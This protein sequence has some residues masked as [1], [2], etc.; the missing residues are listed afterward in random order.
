MPPGLRGRPPGTGAADDPGIRGHAD[1]DG[2]TLELDQPGGQRGQVPAV[3]HLPGRD[4]AV[5][6]GPDPVGDDGAMVPGADPRDGG[7]PC[8]DRD[9]GLQEGRTGRVRRTG[10]QYAGDRSDGGVRGSEWG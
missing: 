2:R 10:Q 9:P 7:A 1:R 4:G 5:Q 3:Y 6:D 8:H